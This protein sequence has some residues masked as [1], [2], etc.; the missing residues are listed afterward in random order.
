MDINSYNQLLIATCQWHKYN[1]LLPLQYI[2]QVFPWEKPAV[3]PIKSARQNRG[4]DKQRQGSPSGISDTHTSQYWRRT[5]KRIPD[6]LTFLSF[7]SFGLDT[8][9]R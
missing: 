1:L 3:D 5:D 7:I 2:I 6:L 4:G 9:T 8:V